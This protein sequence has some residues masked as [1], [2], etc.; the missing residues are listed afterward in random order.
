MEEWRETPV[1]TARREDAEDLQRELAGV[2][3]PRHQRFGVGRLQKEA[4][5]SRKRAEETTRDLATLLQDPAYRALYLQLGNTLSDA[6][7]E[8][9]ATI[10]RLEAQLLQI[11]DDLANMEAEA[12]KGPDGQSVFRYADGRVVNAQGREIAP[13][14]AAGIIWPSGAPTAE[15]YF[16]ALDR[17]D[18]LED[19]LEEWRVYRS[20]TLGAIRDRY[21]DEADPM[22]EVDIQEALDQI[23]HARPILPAEADPPLASEAAPE[24]VPTSFPSFD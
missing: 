3:G 1:E 14:I 11:D 21:E 12:A 19:H 13:E 10:E 5:E 2:V 23:D 4:V 7:Q 15:A 16:T 6:E 9:D 24:V 17:R 20:G 8:A 22:A 18:A